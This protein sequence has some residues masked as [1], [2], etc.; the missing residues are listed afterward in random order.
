[1]VD[2]G[3]GFTIA[4][5]HKAETLVPYFR[6]ERPSGAINHGWIDLRGRPELVPEIP[7]AQKS[8]GLANLLRVMAQQSSKV[9]SSAC[10]CG[11][12]DRGEYADGPRWKA[13]GFVT[14]TFKD[15]DKNADTELLLYFARYILGGIPTTEDHHIVFEMI[16]EPLKL[17]FGRTDCFALSLK[18]IGYGASEE[19]AW[20]A[21]N[22]AA[23]SAAQAIQRGRAPDEQIELYLT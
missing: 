14:I 22:C 3:P 5:A 10:E 17:F 7:E 13:D 18:P 2:E 11:L 12:F 23:N 4:R 1:M 16:I 6:A 9:M 15:A 20:A 19:V 21:F 8:R